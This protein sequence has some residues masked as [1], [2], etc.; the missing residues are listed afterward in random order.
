[1]NSLLLR[2]SVCS[3]RTR[4]GSKSLYCLYWNVTAMNRDRFLSETWWHSRCH[5][6][7]ACY[8]SSDIKGYGCIMYREATNESEPDISFILAGFRWF[9]RFLKNCELAWWCV[10]VGWNRKACTKLDLTFMCLLIWIKNCYRAYS[11]LTK[12]DNMISKITLLCIP[13]WIKVY[14]HYHEYLTTPLL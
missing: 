14:S 13:F 6:K 12:E 3:I 8:L 4:N 1:M 5:C 7:N 2:W 10:D 9:D 11:H